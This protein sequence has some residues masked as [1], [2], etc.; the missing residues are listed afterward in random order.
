MFVS[1]LEL[2]PTQIFDRIPV[3][4]LAL[5]GQ[6]RS[7][8]VFVSQL[9]LGPAM[10]FGKVS[11]SQLALGANSDPTLYAFPSSSWGQLRSLT[12]YLF[13]S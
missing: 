10:I 8:L 13:P 2:G 4:Q 11:V 5:G 1:Q 7:D 12:G 3:S 6:L 9:Q